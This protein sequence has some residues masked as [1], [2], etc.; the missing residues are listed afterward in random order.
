MIKRLTLILAMVGMVGVALLVLKLKQPHPAPI[1]LVEPS[2]APFADSIG[3]RG[4]VES[5]DENVRIA[6][7]VPGVIDE[8]YVKVGD[9]VSKGA[10]LFRGDTRDAEAKVVAQTAQVGLLEAKVKEAEVALADKQDSYRRTE[11]LRSKD[12]SSEDDLQRKL[13]AMR[14]AETSLITARADLE[15]AKAQLK[16][17]QVTLDL[18]TV[19]APREGEILRVDLRAGEY[20]N[21]SPTDPNEPSLLL[22]D[23]RHLQLRAD[24][25]EDSAS[26]VKKGAAAIAF[27]RGMR[28]DPIPLRFVRIE[29]YVTTKK[30]LTGDSTER[31]DTRVLQVIY[32]FDHSSVPVYV[33]QQMDVFIDGRGAPN[34]PRD[35]SNKGVLTLPAP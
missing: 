13:Y 19:R 26:R 34:L 2:K 18:L 27:I 6:P 22:G 24:V 7:V 32:Q 33:G 14:S 31:V 11:Q 15:L 16:Q 21:I 17:A 30:S 23:T 25:D 4:M 8:V 9:H 1:P 12:V 10:P 29:P 35:E 28:S 3:A 20:V 5:V